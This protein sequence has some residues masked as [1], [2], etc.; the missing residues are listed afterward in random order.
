MENLLIILI[1]LTAI[2]FGV[3]MFFLSKFLKEQQ[4]TNE[5]LTSNNKSLSEIK[6]QLDK[7]EAAEKE[8]KSVSQ[9]GFSQIEAALKETIK[10]D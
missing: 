2:G 7:L 10:L 9:T 5:N 8:H 1:V 3:A 6:T 4:L